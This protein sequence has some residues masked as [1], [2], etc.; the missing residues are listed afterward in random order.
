MQE[1]KRA[2]RAE[3]RESIRRAA[4]TPPSE[5]GRPDPLYRE[6]LDVRRRARGELLSP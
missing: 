2:T 1:K 3:R 4:E 6:P 5:V